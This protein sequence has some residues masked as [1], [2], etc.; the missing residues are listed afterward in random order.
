MKKIIFK[1]ITP[2]REVF[3]DEVDQVSL[4]T[5]EGEITVMPDHIPLISILQPSELKY[6]KDG[7]EN[8][9]AISGG[10][11]EVRG[12]NQLVVLGD[13]VEMAEEIDVKRAEEAQKRA[14]QAMEDARLEE[15]VDFV[16]LQAALERSS[17]RIKVVKKY[18]KLP[19][20]V[21]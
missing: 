20:T 6:K 19:P 13:T 15:N 16:A 17:V 4:M 5:S 3:S 12:D 14:K 7:E 2:E 21:Q 9:L 1:I 11:V 18:R 8:V 10:F